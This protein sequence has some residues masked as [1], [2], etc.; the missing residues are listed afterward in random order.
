MVIVNKVLHS[1]TRWYTYCEVYQP[2]LYIG[3][4]Q[5]GQPQ[6]HKDSPQLFL[7]ACLLVQ[8]SLHSQVSFLEE[9][10]FLLLLHFP[11]VRLNQH[12]K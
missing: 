8:G 10:G 5:V 2:C 7:L 3:I 9:F 12:S 6:L 11:V 4:L 1:A